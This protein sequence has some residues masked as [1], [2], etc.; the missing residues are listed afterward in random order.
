MTEQTN[1]SF[2]SF[3]ACGNLRE[4]TRVVTQIFDE[5]FQPIGLRA[6]QFALLVSISR[7]GSANMTQ[8]AEQMLTDRT[9][10][11]R[12]LKPLAKQGLLRVLPGRDLRTREVTLTPRGETTVIQAAPLW[13]KAQ[14][15]V[16][17]GVGQERFN[18]LLEHLSV[19][20]AL[21]R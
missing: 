14:A 18:S 17:G 20:K 3:C 19:V 16:V 9:T 6:T 13:A 2:Q 10:L 7:A 11:T 12:N 8:L 1:L 21:G 5:E 15:R 4:A